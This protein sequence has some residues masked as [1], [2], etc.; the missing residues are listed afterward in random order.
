VPQHYRS[1]SR[2]FLRFAIIMLVFGGLA[3]VLF[4]EMTKHM[5]YADYPPGLRLEGVYH[6][7]LLHGH[8]FLI[9]A[10]MPIAWVVALK[11][12]LELGGKPVTQ[13]ALAWIKWSYLVG[14]VSVLG[15]ITYKGI[16]FVLCLQDGTRDFAQI[17]ESLFGGNH[18]MRGLAYGLSHTVATASL[19]VFGWILWRSLA[20]STDD[21]GGTSSS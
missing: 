10:V 3:G 1:F 14:A 12:G 19:I 17:Q 18:L 4:Q 8:S 20:A 9:G 11:I 21:D 15:L 6:L 7:A 2:T 5:S 16:H 13:R